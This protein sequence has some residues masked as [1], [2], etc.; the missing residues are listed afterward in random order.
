MPSLKVKIGRLGLENPILVSS[1]DLT[2]TKKGIEMADRFGPGAIII[3]SSLLEEEYL[4]VVKPHEGGRFPDVRAKFF[5]SEDGLLVICALSSE[6]IE[7]WAEWLK[8][9]KR[10]IKA[11]LIAS[12]V[13][14]SLEG[15][16]KGAK[17]FEEA[18]ADALEILLACPVPYLRRFKYTSTLDP[19]VI[20]EVCKAVRKAV[21]IP[22]GAKIGPF[23]NLIRIVKEAGLDFATV[24]YVGFA[25]PGIDLERIEPL[26]PST[27]I[28]TGSRVYKH[29]IFHGLSSIPELTREF[30]VSATGGI[31]DW[32]DI[33]E[34]IMYGA[35]SVQLQTILMRKGFGIIPE[36]KKDLLG[37]MERK[38]FDSLEEMRELILPKLLSFD[39][40]IAAYGPTKGKVVAKVDLES[41]NLC[42]ICQDV[43]VYEA[44]CISEEE[45]AINKEGCEGCNLCVINCPQEALTLENV[46]LIRKVVGR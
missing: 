26:L 39:E 10:E 11:P 22:L 46:D 36:L 15:Y 14:I 37:Y 45:I 19:H 21:R 28:L 3:K 20:S 40:C 30:H 2:R 34:Y 7:Q 27:I 23:P 35:T 18:G 32:Q 5:P 38:G 41:C 16:V 43:C 13:A 31:Q 24:G 6:P 1:G 4:Q 9:H 29:I 25:S 33:A 8:N 42:G 12:Q 17:L 44:I